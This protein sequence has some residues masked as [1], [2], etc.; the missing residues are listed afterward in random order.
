MTKRERVNAE[1]EKNK[2]K[3][4]DL[5]KQNLEI[6]K[7]TLLLSDKKQWFTEEIESHPRAKW[8][9]KDNELDGKL[10]GRIHWNQSFEDK[11]TGEIVTIERSRLVRVDGEFV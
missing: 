2:E 6:H 10:V 9:R 7:E 5:N 1:I 8:Q 3:I 11:G 4:R